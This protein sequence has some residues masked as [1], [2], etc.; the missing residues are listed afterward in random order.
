MYNNDIYLYSI[1]YIIYTI[2]H[3]IYK[4]RGLAWLESGMQ[5]LSCG[6][7]GAVYL[8]YVVSVSIHMCIYCVVVYNK[9][10]LCIC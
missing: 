6:Q 8:W 2:L 3:N 10:N 4:V 5:L 9:S 7:E 1:Y